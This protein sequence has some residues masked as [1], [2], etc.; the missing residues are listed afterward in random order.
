MSVSW[1]SAGTTS[2]LLTTVPSIAHG[3]WSTFN[4]Q[5][6]LNEGGRSRQAASR[7]R[8]GMGTH[9]CMG[10]REGSCAKPE[11]EAASSWV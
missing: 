7:S 6:L 1:T 8:Q 4:A 11:S 10:A 5:V 9:E 2:V 3:A